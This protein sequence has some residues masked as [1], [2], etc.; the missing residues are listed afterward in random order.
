MALRLVR[1]GR[2]PRRGKKLV[3]EFS[4]GTVSHFGAEGY[5]DFTVYWAA[6]PEVAARKRRQYIARHAA[7]ERWDDPRSPA[8]LARYILWE[9][10][11]VAAA[12]LAYRRRFAV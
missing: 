2:S 10:P 3:A 11:T 8:T 9:R 6:D 7:T 1:L 12:A 4:D 5:R